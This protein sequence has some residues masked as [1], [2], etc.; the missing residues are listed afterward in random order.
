MLREDFLVSRNADIVS[1]PHDLMSCMNLNEHG[2][3]ITF[4]SPRLFKNRSRNYL[5]HIK[6]IRADIRPTKATSSNRKGTMVRHLF[7]SLTTQSLLMN[8]AQLADHNVASGSG[9]ATTP[10]TVKYPSVGEWPSA[11][12]YQSGI[13][14]SLSALKYP[15]SMGSANKP[16]NSTASPKT[17]GTTPKP[18][19]SSNI[20][21]RS[22]HRCG[23]NAVAG[24]CHTGGAECLKDLHLTLRAMKPLPAA[25][26]VPHERQQRIAMLE[27]NGFLHELLLCACTPP[28][29]QQKHLAL[30]VLLWV[31]VIRMGRFRAPRT[32]RASD[33]GPVRMATSTVRGGL[34]C[35]TEMAYQQRACVQTVQQHLVELLRHCILNGNR[36]TASKCVKLL[37]VLTE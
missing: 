18:M 8:T 6:T 37:L 5:I 2:G 23:P 19:P 33:G 28:N 4:T 21:Q 26:R 12:K 22:R 1:G 15:S 25:H 17:T 16:S 9:Y 20:G 3:L 30:D 31:L 34:D 36:S 14:D 13:L 10:S 32:Q 7:P 35:A 29:A 27:S 24:G 11:A